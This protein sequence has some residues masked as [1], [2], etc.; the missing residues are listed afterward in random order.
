[1]DRFAGLTVRERLFEQGTL[2]EFDDA[3]T[4]RDAQ[5]VR[6]LLEQVEVD[7]PSISHTISNMSF[8]APR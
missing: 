8:Y 6:R 2:D 1:V 4:R 7:E 5:T 3:L